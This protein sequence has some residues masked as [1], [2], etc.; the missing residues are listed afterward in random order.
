MSL[1]VL[2]SHWLHPDRT[3]YG[4]HSCSLELIYLN[5]APSGFDFAGLS[6]RVNMV[7]SK[8]ADLW[9]RIDWKPGQVL[10]PMFDDGNAYQY[11]N[12]VQQ[13]VAQFH[14]KGVIIGN[15]PNLHSETGGTEMQAWW[16]ARMVYGH[17]LPSDRTDCAFQFAR[18]ADAS[19]RVLVPAVAPWSPDTAG[20]THGLVWPDGRSSGLPHESYTYDLSRS[21]YQSCFEGHV[22]DIGDINF[23]DHVYGRVGTGTLNG[24]AN[25]PFT[26]VRGSTGAQF[27]SR[28]FQDNLYYHR[29]GQLQ[30]GFGTDYYPP[31]LIGE[32]NTLVDTNPDVNYPIGWEKN[33]V[34]YVRQFP[35]VMGL[36]MFVDQDLGGN[37]TH[38]AMT[39]NLGH[40]PLWNR[41]H[42]ELLRI[43]W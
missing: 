7:K 10:P 25:E 6:N 41:D 20:D 34:Y 19:V 33:L 30:S 23:C 31:V 22:P 2:G 26:D 36:C 1:D 11:C 38:T 13:V 14:P 35:N 42:D 16:V 4:R 40:E 24:G 28:W 39:A 9:I 8:G 3:L 15:E 17:T 12:G 27:G 18:T 5:N 37:W 21:C 32:S 43:G 29:Q